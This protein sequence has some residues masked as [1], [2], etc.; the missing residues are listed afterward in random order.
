[1]CKRFITT[2]TWIWNF[3]IQ[4][5][6]NLRFRFKLIL[7][8][9]NALCIFW[10]GITNHNHPG[11]VSSTG[12]RCARAWICNYIHS[13]IWDVITHPCPNF[14]GIL[15]EL[16]L[17]LRHGWISTRHCFVWS[18]LWTHALKSM[19]VYIMYVGKSDLWFLFRLRWRRYW[20]CAV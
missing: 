18:W 9:R 4:S 12:I 3:N 8:L 6:Y 1:M 13:S 10:D 19:L 14:N 20:C 16:P 15:K 17:K 7:R 5:T 2:V 11:L